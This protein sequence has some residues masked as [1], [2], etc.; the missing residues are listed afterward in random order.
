MARFRCKNEKCELL[1]KD[2]FFAKISWRFDEQTKSMELKEKYFCEK[3]NSELTYQK[4]EYKGDICFN[5][6]AFNTKSD[7][8]K[9]TILKKRA[10]DHTRTKMKDRIHSIKKKFGAI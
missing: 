5:Y 3:C 8:E 6:G 10:D 7:Q 4:E 9:K 2:Q 1:E